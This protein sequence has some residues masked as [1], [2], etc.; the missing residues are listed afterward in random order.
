MIDF[1][2]LGFGQ[3][4]WGGWLVAGAVMTLAVTLCAL[5]VGAVIGALVAWAKALP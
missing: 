2:L 1:S 3:G 5:F 4:G